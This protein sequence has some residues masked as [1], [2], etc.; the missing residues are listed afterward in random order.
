MILHISARGK[1]T[2][3]SNL[4]L[5]LLKAKQRHK[6]TRSEVAI[7]T[8]VVFNINYPTIEPLLNIADYFCWAI[9]RVF[10][11][12]EIRFYDYLKEKISLVIDLNDTEKYEGFKNYYGPKNPLTIANKKSP[13]VH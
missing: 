9:Q 2:K 4:E 5:A 11:R 1:S 6:T 12:G 10:E 8:N 13:P 3:N 7:T